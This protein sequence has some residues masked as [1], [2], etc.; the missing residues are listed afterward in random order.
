MRGSSQDLMMKRF[1]YGIVPP[2]NYCTHFR[3]HTAGINTLIKLNDGRIV[4]GTEEGTLCIWDSTTGDLLKRMVLQHI[5]TR[6]PPA[7]TKVQTDSKY[8]DTT[9]RPGRSLM[10]SS[11]FLAGRTR[12]SAV[13]TKV[14]PYI[15]SRHLNFEK[16][17]MKFCNKENILVLQ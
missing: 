16:K 12:Y 7:P 3:G 10:S 9:T 6:I 2:V 13:F 4:S 5:A 14:Q 15:I 1:A 8:S 11:F 17:L